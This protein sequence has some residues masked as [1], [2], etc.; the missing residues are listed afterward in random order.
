MRRKIKG[1]LNRE[2]IL[3]AAI[4]IFAENGMA[5]SSL[6]TIARKAKLTKAGIL[7][8]FSSKEDLL[9]EAAKKVV[10]HNLELVAQAV[11]ETQPAIK[12]LETYYVA[13]LRWAAEFP[14]E[15]RLI[16]LLFY[17]ASA[18]DGSAQVTSDVL[19][20]GL[21]RVQTYLL[22]A[23]REGSVD[24]GASVK[25]LATAIHDS[26]IGSFVRL[27]GPDRTMSPQ[28]FIALRLRI[29]KTWL[30]PVTA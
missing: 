16:L 19:N 9:C 12:Q 28:A 2:R 3:E 17:Q 14:E 27:G 8:H 18:H 23:Q 22:A 11:D 6:D 30:T 29:W 20:K 24:K 7:Y 15:A 26:L 13:S 1:P 4:A 25:D 10:M 21:T 5:G